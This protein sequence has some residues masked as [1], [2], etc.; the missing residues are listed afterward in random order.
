MDLKKKLK[1]EG[2]LKGKYFGRINKIVKSYKL[3]FFFF[4]NT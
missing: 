2:K 4:L 3:I 1:I